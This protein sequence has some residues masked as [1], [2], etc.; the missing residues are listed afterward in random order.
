M[1]NELLISRI[2]AKT[3]EYLDAPSV[4][5]HEAPFLDHLARDFRAAGLGVTRQRN[6]AII[7]TGKSGPIFFAH[8][9]RHGAVMDNEGTARFAAY[10]VKSDKY[11][12]TVAPTAAFAAR[13]DERFRGETMYAYDRRTGGRLAYAVI[14]G[15]KL[16][17]SLQQIIFRF[18]AM[19]P[20]P[21]GTPIAFARQQARETGAAV[22]GQ[23]DNPLSA[24]MLR[25]LT[26]TGLRGRIVFAAEEEIGR[27]AAHIL[28]WMSDNVGAWNR[29]IVVDTTPFDDTAALDA[30][31][32][33]LRNRDAHAAFDPALTAATQSLASE[34]GLPFAF[35]DKLIEAQNAEAVRQGNPE[36]G[37]GMTELG[38]MIMLSGGEVTGTTVQVPTVGYHTNHETT[39]RRAIRNTARLLLELSRAV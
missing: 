38:R 39:S 3:N 25:V 28:S 32:V 9:D 37:L 11:N 24:A 4:V 19:P 2:V 12:E 27:S 8:I 22:S 6:L 20:L 35:K 18:D 14:Q 13:L 16:H 10:A 34:L 5:G 36:K 17:E 31:T 15:I 26:E 21:A 33:I 1:K 29:C 30:G 7:D 23:L